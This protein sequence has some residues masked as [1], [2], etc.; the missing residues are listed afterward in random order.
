MTDMTDTQAGS[1]PSSRTL[2]VTPD[3][4]RAG[5]VDLSILDTIAWDR[6]DRGPGRTPPQDLIRAM[7]T[8]DDDDWDGLL[9]SDLADEVMNQGTCYP[10][11]PAVVSVLAELAGSVALS[12]RRRLD[13]HMD[14]LAIGGRALYD[15]VADAEEGLAP[16]VD[17]WTAAAHAAVGA[18]VPALLAHWDE[19][20]P[21]VQF[22]LAILA[23]LY[24]VQGAS[25]VA[26]IS[27]FAG[28][29]RGTEPGAYVNLA[30]A[31]LAGDDAATLSVARDITE[32]DEEVDADWLNLLGLPVR[33]TCAHLMRLGAM[34]IATNHD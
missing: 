15:Q 25:A 33:V 28:E 1:V 16:Q 26:Q 19:Q 9:W 30:L 29:Y 17:E 22:A 31:L 8:A 10:V 23:G 5:P 13:L 2:P 7:V 14:L 24:P 11:T 32:W 34:I 6:L 20:P 18:A 12:G 21:A 4:Y 3:H 27:R